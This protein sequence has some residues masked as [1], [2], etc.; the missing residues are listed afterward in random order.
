MARRAPDAAPV[1]LPAANPSRAALPPGVGLMAVLGLVILLSSTLP[2]VRQHV[3]LMQAHRRLQREV[4][5]ASARAESLRQ[6]L[7]AAAQESFLRTKAM[8]RL[9]HQ[10]G[11]YIAERDA[12]LAQ[13]GRVGGV[14]EPAPVPLR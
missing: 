7:R 14:D 4:A 8:R 10:G 3:A 12:R 1:L 9:W 2:S 5:E 13:D 11:R 6:E